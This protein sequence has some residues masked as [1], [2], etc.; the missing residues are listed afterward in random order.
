MDCSSRAARQRRQI[1]PDAL[2]DAMCI[3]L[4]KQLSIDADNQVSTRSMDRGQLK[5]FI[6]RLGIGERKLR[7]DHWT[8]IFHEQD[9]QPATRTRSED[10]SKGV[11]H[12]KDQLSTIYNSAQDELGWDDLNNCPLDIELIRKA[13]EVKIAYFRKQGVYTKLPR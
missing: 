5:S 6:G 9:G 7:R 2:C 10:E 1:Y 11:Q 13:R 8:D 3:G 12:L 4:K